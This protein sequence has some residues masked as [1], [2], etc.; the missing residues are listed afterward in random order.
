MDRLN[1]CSSDRPA[2]PLAKGRPRVSS[3][4]YRKGIFGVCPRRR[5]ASIY[6]TLL[7]PTHVQLAGEVDADIQ[8]AGVNGKA[9]IRKVYKTAAFSSQRRGYRL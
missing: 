9:T 6:T 2:E 4:F 3:V 1:N 8:I 5:S 7:Q